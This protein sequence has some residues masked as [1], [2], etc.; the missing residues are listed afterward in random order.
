[1]QMVNFLLLGFQSAA[2]FIMWILAFVAFIAMGLA[3]ER[4]WYLFLK[5]DWGSSNFMS[6][7]N[8]YIKA[9]DFER[10]AKYA[11]SVKSPLAKGV[12]GVLLN[13]DKGPKAIK[14]AVDEVF[15]TEGPKVKRN[16]FLLNTFAN[17][18][19]LIGLTGT[20]YGTMEC[21]DAIANAPA[22]QRAQQLAAGISITMSATLMGLLVAVPCIMVHG[23]LSGKADKIMEDMDEKTTKLI[24]AVEE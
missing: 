9:G 15:L 14:K 11:A 4:F 1:M 17:L 3:A 21:F 6:A 13:R 10:A 22:A 16:V 24:N 20:I 18:A 2:S 19:T 5:C 7:I 8:K 23:M 12:A